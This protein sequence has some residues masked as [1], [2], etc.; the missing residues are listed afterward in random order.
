MEKPFDDN[1]RVLFV[2]MGIIITGI[3]LYVTTVSIGYFERIPWDQE[4]WKQETF[5]LYMISSLL[6][7]FIGICFLGISTDKIEKYNVLSGIQKAIVIFN[8][9]LGGYLGYTQVSRIFNLY[10]PIVLDVELKSKAGQMLF[11]VPFLFFMFFHSFLDSWKDKYWEKVSTRRRSKKDEEI[12]KNMSTI[13]EK[14]FS[15]EYLNHI[16]SKYTNKKL[17]KRKRLEKSGDVVAA[18]LLGVGVYIATVYVIFWSDYD[19]WVDYILPIITTPIFVVFGGFFIFM[20]FSELFIWLNMREGETSY[21]FGKPK[22]GFP[23][24]KVHFEVRFSNFKP[25]NVLPE[26][27]LMIYNFL[28]NKMAN[29]I[30]GNDEVD[31]ESNLKIFK[32]GDK[33]N[34]E[35]A[36][37]LFREAIVPTGVFKEIKDIAKE[38]GLGAIDI[39]KDLKQDVEKYIKIRKEMKNF[40]SHVAL[41]N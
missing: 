35:D 11:G 16:I 10:L 41:K 27:A 2:L 23:V 21:H 15:N 19:N 4:Y 17:V 22:K 8:F 7:L 30:E 37:K 9:F 18:S 20:A 39:E 38:F 1:R 34:H 28:M 36:K 40:M 32:N 33:I 29:R 12:K 31:E 6:V 24:E 5:Q 13:S 26:E 3:G 14:I 25:L